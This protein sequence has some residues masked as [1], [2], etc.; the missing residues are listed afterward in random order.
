MKTIS[1]RTFLSPRCSKWLSA[2]TQNVKKPFP[3]SGNGFGEIIGDFSNRGQKRPVG[4]DGER[5]VRRLV[6]A[7]RPRAAKEK[8]GPKTAFCPL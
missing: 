8:G 2:R 3:L 7:V 5:R 6:R 1:G 4:A